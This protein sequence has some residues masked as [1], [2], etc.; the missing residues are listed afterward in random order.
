VHKTGNAML[1]DKYA[2]KTALRLGVSPESVRAEFKKASRI[3]GTTPAAAEET[4]SVEK[5]VAT[6]MPRPSAPEFWLLKLA[7]LHED[8]VEWLQAHLDLNWVQHERVRQTISLRLNA[9]ANDTWQ[10]IAAFL[11]ECEH[12]DMQNLITE[13]TAENRAVAN[14]QQQLG[15]I[16]LRLRNQFIDRQL[17]VLTQRAHQPGTGEEEHLSVMREQ[18]VLR[19]LK[20]QP[21][22]PLA[23]GV[24][25]PF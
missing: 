13:A 1:V 9:R 17:A 11:A 8:S 2:Q 23:G 18:Q 24:E 7:L 15:D 22:T 6:E 20:R 25:E 19:E 10:G 16:L 3:K 14:A 12:G 4:E 21:L 5:E